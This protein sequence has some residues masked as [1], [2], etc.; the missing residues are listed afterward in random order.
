MLSRG[1]VRCVTP[2]V[3]P[4]LGRR[5][6]TPNTMSATNRNRIVIG[7]RIATPPPHV[8]RLA[9]PSGSVSNVGSV[10]SLP[11][12]APFLPLA[13]PDGLQPHSLVLAP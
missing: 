12:P 9:L 2:P 10:T 13:T 7:E 5:A 8:K 1:E 3:L 11:C 6:A 4:F